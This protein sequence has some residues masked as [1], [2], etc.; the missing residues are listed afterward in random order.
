MAQGRLSEILDDPSTTVLDAMVASM[1]LKT[2]EYGDTGRFDGLCNRTIGKVKDEVENFEPPELQKLR[3]L[4]LTELILFV[5][6]NIP[7]A[8]NAQTMALLHEPNSRQELEL[9]I[10]RVDSGTDDRAKALADG[11]LGIP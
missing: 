4:S 8:L 10:T 9:G 11:E 5:K 1:M 6:T 2:I 3:H 7:E